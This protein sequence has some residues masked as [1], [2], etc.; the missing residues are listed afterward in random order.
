MR[1]KKVIQRVTKLVAG[2]SIGFL[3]PV[4]I[5]A[6]SLDVDSTGRVTVQQGEAQPIDPENPENPGD[7][8]EGPSTKGALRFDYVSSLDFGEVVISPTNREY[9][10]LAQQF[11]EPA[12]GP[13]GSFIQLSDHRTTSTGWT[14]QVKQEQAFTHESTEPGKNQLTGATLSLDKVWAN[15]H[16]TSTAPSVTRDP[17]TL[18]SIGTAQTIA[19]S[20]A[21]TG[22]GVWTIAFGGSKQAPVTIGNTL[23]PVKD[24]QG[25]PVLDEWSGKPAYH[26]HAITLSVPD[27]TPIVA[28]EYQ[29]TLTWILAALP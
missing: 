28:T 6:S 7:P 4:T 13:R 17:I 15:S 29:T 3:W 11:K 8:G 19:T 18:D 22:R 20:E 12:I 14:L 5:Q 1:N 9:P 27:G 10:A 21:G 24:A 2:V 23:I 25:N 26:N 16:G